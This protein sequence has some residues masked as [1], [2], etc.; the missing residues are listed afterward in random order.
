MSSNDT[1][2][3]AATFPPGSM[4]RMRQ[5]GSQ[6]RRPRRSS[7]RGWIHAAAG[8][9]PLPWIG[10]LLRGSGTCLTYHRVLP[11][12][13]LLEQERGGFAPNIELSV[14][15][16]EFDLQIAYLARNYHPLSVPEATERLARGELPDR[17]VLITFDDGYRDNLIHALPV[18]RRHGVP[19]AFY[20]TTAM[21]DRAILP[22]W[23]EL[24]A[25]LAASDRIRLSWRTEE[26]DFTLTGPASRH[27]AFKR[28]GMVLKSRSPAEQEELMAILRPQGGRES[29]A[30][31]TREAIGA[32]CEFLSWPE[33]RELAADP[34]VTI[35]CH[36]RNHFVL[37]RLSVVELREE[38]A[39]GRQRLERELNGPVEHL[40][41]P[42]GGAADAAEREFGMAAELGFRSAFTTQPGHLHRLHRERMHSLPRVFVS[43]YDT[44]DSLQW[45][46]SGFSAGIR[47]L[48][49]AWGWRSR[50]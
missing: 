50:R 14:S 31:L 47:Q 4:E 2:E 42:Y 29:R 41:Y 20:L 39:Q 15:V 19:A 38:L 6:R 27:L 8:L 48:G 25:I 49:A 11:K 22:W 1:P 10:G 5:L 9:P 26:I 45:K 7:L 43:Y 23:Y 21:I 28:L 3:K 12:E 33:V 46:L 13:R 30:G 36:T 34:R 17:S 37:S 40:A 16:E 32:E 44:L 24:G 18:L 35:G